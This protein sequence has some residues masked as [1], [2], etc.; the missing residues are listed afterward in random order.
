MTQSAE[1]PTETFRKQLR[2][3]RTALG[4]SAQQLADRVAELGGSLDRAA[5]AKIEA[6]GR[7]DLKPRRLQFDEAL[8]LAA[9]LGVSPL[10]LIVPRDDKTPVALAP[11]LTASARDAR[12]WVRGA[13]PLPGHPAG[14]YFS[15]VPPA[16]Y[17][18]IADRADRAYADA[19][20]LRA[21]GD[22][23]RAAA[24][25]DE[26]DRL[27]EQE[28]DADLERQRPSERQRLNDAERLIRDSAR[29]LRS[30]PPEELQRLIDH[31]DE[32]DAR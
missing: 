24:I 25:E 23:E 13:R 12:A 26:A 22:V 20:K 14:A 15:E 3:T 10:H 30:L 29:L 19:Q 8:L 32:G 21:A 5:I 2:R 9:A 17:G 16:E 18:R 28:Q 27:F 6:D 1:T 4:L 7:G 31:D 11:H